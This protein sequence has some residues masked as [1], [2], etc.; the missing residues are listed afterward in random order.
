MNRLPDSVQEIADV[1]GRDQALMLIGALPRCY[2]GQPGKK[3]NQVVMYVPTVKNLRLD[4]QLVRILG[5][6]DAE[7][8]CRTFGGEI[9]KPANCAFIQREFLHK[10]ILGMMHG[11]RMK[12]AE[13]AAIVGVH[14][15]TVRNV[16]RENPPE[17]LF[18]A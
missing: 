15:R 8:L 3:S 7:R 1:I 18:A 5:W 13:V 17:E 10:T 2:V 16:V 9:M 14:E 11:G 12:A 4:H 6:I